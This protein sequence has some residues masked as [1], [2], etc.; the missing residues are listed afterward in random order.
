MATTRLRSPCWLLDD[1]KSNDAANSIVVNET[2][3]EIIKLLDLARAGRATVAG[4]T[5]RASDIAIL[6][7]NRAQGREI[8]QALR[9]RGG[10]CVEIDDSSVFGTREAQQLHRLLLALANPGRQDFKR[11][12]LTGDFVRTGQQTTAGAERGRRALE[13]LDKAIR[14]V[15]RNLA[16]ARRWGDAA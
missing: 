13:F 5:L 1:Q 9:R 15:A 7:P 8:A 16:V 3:N 6:V 2:A 10:K 14:S 4:R 11:A 12:A